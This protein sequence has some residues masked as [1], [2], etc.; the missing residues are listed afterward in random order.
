MKML[1]ALLVAVALFV[2]AFAQKTTFQGTH[3]RPKLPVVA[4]AAKPILLHTGKPLTQ[5]DKQLLLASTI[6]TYAAKLPAGTKK[7]QVS[8]APSTPITLTPDQMYKNGVVT[9]QAI[10]PSYVDLSQGIFGFNPGA[11]SF[12]IFNINVNPNTAYTLDFKVSSAGSETSVTPHFT[13]FSGVNSETIDFGSYGNEEFAYAFVSASA[14]EI[15]V[16]VYSPNN[17]WYLTSCEIIATP[18]N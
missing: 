12:L 17:G 6:K 14:G 5:N 1:T 7:P 18:L 2:P 3:P 13:I 11:S 8:N 10:S 16:N 9:T 15:G 4:P